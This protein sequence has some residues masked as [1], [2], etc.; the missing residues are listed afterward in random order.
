MIPSKNTDPFYYN[1]DLHDHHNYHHYLQN[2]ASLKCKDKR[3][4]LVEIPKGLIEVLQRNGFTIEKILDSEPTYIA[5]KLGV[6]P[7][8]GKI[9]FHET[10]KA[11]NK[12]DPDLLLISK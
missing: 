12:I 11:L 8:I 4:E 9:I 1:L 7:Y 3:L 5:E 6:D 2:I 10:E